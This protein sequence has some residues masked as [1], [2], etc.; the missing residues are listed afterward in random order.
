MGGKKCQLL[1][2]LLFIFSSQNQ[3]NK[4][5]AFNFPYGAGLYV[6]NVRESVQVTCSIREQSARGEDLHNL[7]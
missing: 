4:F 1:C 5:S 2:S 6:I 3:L 7:I